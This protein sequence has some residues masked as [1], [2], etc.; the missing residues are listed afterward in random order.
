MDDGVA[1]SRKF[2]HTYVVFVVLCTDTGFGV[3]QK[4]AVEQAFRA[5]DRRF[6][7]PQDHLDVAY[8]DQP[9]RDGHLHISAPHIYGCVVEALEVE[10]AMS[11]LNIGSGTGYV[12]AIVGQ[13]L[14]PTGSSFGVEIHQE[15]V[16]HCLASMQRWED[17]TTGQLQLPYTKFIH[18]NGLQIDVTKG[19]AA[20]GFHR[21]YVGASISNKQ[22]TQLVHLLRVGGVL[23]GPGT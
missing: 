13:L 20:I 19:E 8:S 22:L 3:I 5:V 4:H 17:A 18:G 6:F 1:H 7:V 23:V 11:F 9:L 12:S 21:I 10:P 14:G 16:D 15:T 2:S